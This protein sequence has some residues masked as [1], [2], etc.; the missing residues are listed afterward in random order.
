[1]VMNVGF[2]YVCGNDKSM[3]AFGETHA[4]FIADFVCKLRRDFPRL[5][6]LPYLIGNDIACLLSACNII[7][8]PLREHK[9]CLHCSWGALVRGQQFTVICFVGIFRIIGAVSKTIRNGFPFVLVHKNKSCGSD[10]NTSFGARKKSCRAATLLT[11]TTKFCPNI[12]FYKSSKYPKK[13][14][15][16]CTLYCTYR[17]LLFQIQSVMNYTHHHYTN[18]QSILCLVEHFLLSF[19]NKEYPPHLLTIQ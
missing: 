3:V 10:N 18:T 12:L 19:A 8:L 5:K 15:T 11:H 17:Y 2:V 4:K 13:H 1:M 14:L 6:G 9:Y 16:E 7:I